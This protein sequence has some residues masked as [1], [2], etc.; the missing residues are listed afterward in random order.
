MPVRALRKGFII[1]KL[2]L[3]DAYHPLEGAGP[4]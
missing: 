3:G 4:K 2:V 1:R